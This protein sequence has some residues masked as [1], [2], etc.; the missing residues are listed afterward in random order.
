MKDWTR[1]AAALAPDIPAADAAKAAAP[2]EALEA[3]FR[4]LVTDLPPDL[5]PAVEFRAD[6]VDE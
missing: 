6:E 1:I 3:V 2:L 5:E 4:P